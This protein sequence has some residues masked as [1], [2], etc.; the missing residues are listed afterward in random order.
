MSG[1]FGFVGSGSPEVSARMAQDVARLDSAVAS[2]STSNRHAVCAAGLCRTSA[3]VE[4]DGKVLAL[5]GHPFIEGEKRRI[6][7]IDDIAPIAFDRLVTGGRDALRTL[8]GD[9]ALAFAEPERGLALLAV[10]RM[11]IRSLVYALADRTLVFGPGCDTVKCHPA[12]RCEIDVQQLYNYVY[13]HTVPG[14]ATIYRDVHRILPG[15]CVVF[16]NG[17]ASAQRYWQMPFDERARDPFQQLRSRFKQTLSTAVDTCTHAQATGTFLSGGTDSSTVSG[18]LAR[19]ENRGTPA[20]SIGFDASGYDEMEFARI[21][22][23]H[24]GLEHHE[25]YVTPRDVVDA[26]PRIAA[27]YDQPFGNASAV[28]TYFCAKLAREHGV[29]RLLA[30]DGGDELFG[31][32]SRYAKQQQFALYECIPRSLRQ[33]LIEPTAKRV[34]GSSWL[35]QK[36]RSYIAQASLPMPDRYESYNLLERLG[37]RTIFTDDFLASIDPLAPRACQ[38]ETYRDTDAQ[39]LINRMLAYDFRFTLAD[40]DLPKV[41]RMC[42]LAGVDVAF[43]LLDDAVVAFSARLAPRDKLRGTRLRYFFK[44]AL[45]DFL[46]PEVIAKQKHGFGLPFGVWLRNDPALRELAG[47]SLT[48][49]RARGFVRPEFVARLLDRDITMHAGYY[50]TM[51]WILMMLEQ[52]H[53]RER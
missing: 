50:G 33:R 3:L 39:S 7:A 5:W 30:G 40:N 19:R 1:V 42:E 32:N 43:P 34:P 53:R 24:F 27:A 17:T 29:S 37:P 28:P 13:F 36:A 48:A 44:R 12:V 16:A 21:A 35:S 11:G 45:G 51:V 4:R 6:V 8:G 52:W 47:D 26:V 49:I 18:F 41:T 38:R 22:A 2:S 46:P 14:P 20:F 15:H 23:R 9:F 10:D 31:G 25:Y